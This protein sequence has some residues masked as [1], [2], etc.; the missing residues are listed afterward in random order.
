MAAPE[1]LLAAGSGLCFAVIG[2]ALRAGEGRGRDPVLIFTGL[3]ILGALWFLPQIGT[4]PP[5]AAL[6]L[7]A[8]AGLSQHAAIVVFRAGLAV[9][10]LTPLW[11]A[12]LLG[13]LEP[14]AWTA[15]A[16]GSRP[17]PGQWWAMALAAAAIAVAAGLKGRGAGRGPAAS[18]LAYPA[19]LLAALVLNGMAGVCL[20]EADRR[21]LQDQWPAVMAGM[22]LGIIAAALPG[23]LRAR[24]RAGAWRAAAPWSVL[25][26]AG[27]IGGLLLLRLCIAAP[28]G[29]V[30]TAQAVASILGVAVAGVALFGE[31]PS[32]AWW[33]MVLLV[34]GAVA[35][36]GW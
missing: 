9:G 36:A 33:A 17:T 5:A 24:P 19:L 8:I 2:I 16:H 23:L 34:L 11:A 12:M 32:P 22:Y 15:L 30:F 4:A 29:L 21:G 31:R 10:P 3:A 14:V 27:S 13:F 26:A 35:A 6:V 20:V 1:A 25:A 28:A 7:G 18:R